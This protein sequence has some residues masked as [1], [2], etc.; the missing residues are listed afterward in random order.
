MLEEKIERAHTSAEIRWLRGQQDIVTA[1]SKDPKLEELRY[2]LI[3]A[4]KE[5]YQYMEAAAK[6][7][8]ALVAAG[9]G[10]TDP[11]EIKAREQELIAFQERVD[12]DAEDLKSK[13]S[14]AEK[15]IQTYVKGKNYEDPGSTDTL[16]KD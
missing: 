4:N 11:E 7:R 6:E 15:T 13:I 16:P 5:E 14:R 10:V 9:E 12:R 1:Q 2:I 8:D 3:A